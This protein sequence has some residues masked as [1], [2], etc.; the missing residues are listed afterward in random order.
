MDINQLKEKFLALYGKSDA[1]IRV[2]FCPGR[3]NL[4]G[5]HT[6]YKRRARFPMCV[7]LWYLFNHPQNFGKT[8][9]FYF[10]NFD[11]KISVPLD[12][13]NENMAQNG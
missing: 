3:V 10:H 2:F 5:E 9:S 11:F 6:D 1:S 12:K 8:N 13:I 4:I 7:E